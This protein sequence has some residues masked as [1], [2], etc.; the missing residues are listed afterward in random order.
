[1]LIVVDFLPFYNDE[2]SHQ[3]FKFLLYSLADFYS[4]MY[5][6]SIFIK[7]IFL[8]KYANTCIQVN[9]MLYINAVLKTRQVPC[10]VD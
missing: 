5:N 2:V 10:K 1:M 7:K 8:S 6:K 3:N 4:K 9:T